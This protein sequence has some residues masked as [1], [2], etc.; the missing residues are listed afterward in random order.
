VRGAFHAFVDESIRPDGFYRLT[1]VRLRSQDLAAISR[2]VRR[3]IPKGQQR[4][5]FS[6]ERDR[7]RREILRSY[8]ALDISAVTLLTPYGRQS[9]DQVARNRCLRA[10]ALAAVGLE[11]V[12]LVLDS[13]GAARDRLDRSTLGRALARASNDRIVY[14]HRGSR[15][16]VLLALPDA[17]GWA[18]GAGNP[19]RATVEPICELRIA[20]E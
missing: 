9:D 10:L 4:V 1:A 8:V 13:R 6:A 15:D 19:W 17:I 12:S 5:H 3:G 18:I 11:I 20:P 7:R 2:V 14:A 16:E